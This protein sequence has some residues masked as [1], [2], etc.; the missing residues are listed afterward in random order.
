MNGGYICQ[1]CYKS[2]DILEALGKLSFID[3]YYQCSDC[4]SDL[5]YECAVARQIHYDNK[6]LKGIP[7]PQWLFDELVDKGLITEPSRKYSKKEMVFLKKAGALYEFELPEEKEEKPKLS[8]E[9]IKAAYESN[10]NRL[11]LK[12][13]R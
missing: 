11:S 1:S 7:Y 6:R 9:V 12:E 8:K 10:I 5:E 4:H 3:G 2:K 13:P